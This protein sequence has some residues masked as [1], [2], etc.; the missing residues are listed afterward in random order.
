MANFFVVLLQDMLQ[1][2]GSMRR[3]LGRLACLLRQVSIS[4]SFQAHLSGK[5]VR[6]FFPYQIFRALFFYESRKV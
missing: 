5:E 4:P 6:C 3:S 2:M 1:S